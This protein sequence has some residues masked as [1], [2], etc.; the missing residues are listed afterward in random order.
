LQTDFRDAHTVC[1]ACAAARDGIYNSVVLVGC[2][3]SRW[4]RMSDLD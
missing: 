3:K 1:A 4:L 2:E